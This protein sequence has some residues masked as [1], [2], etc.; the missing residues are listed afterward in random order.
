[1]FYLGLIVST[2]YVPGF[3]GAL[4]PT[5]WALLSIIL[6]FFLWRPVIPGPAFWLGASSFL[7]AIASVTWAP[8]ILSAAFGLWHFL[9]WALAFRL[10]ATNLDLPALFRGLAIGLTINSGVAVLQAFDLNPVQSQP[11]IAPAGLLFN[12]T[13]LGAA[14]ALTIVALL[15]L[16]QFRYLLGPLIGLALTESRGAWLILF[17]GLASRMLPRTVL[18][19]ALVPLAYFITLYPANSDAVRLYIWAHA[20]AHLSA[21]GNGIG[22]FDSYYYV[23]H[24]LLFRDPR[25]IHP[26]FVHNDYLQLWFELGI[27]AIP[28]YAILAIALGQTKFPLRATLLSAAISGLFYF[29]LW[30]PLIAFILCVLT[31][32]AVANWHYVRRSIVSWR[33]HDVP[34]ADSPR[35]IPNPSR[36]QNLPA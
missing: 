19:L 6:P 21:W 10:G 13:I 32:R 9:V 15:E 3:T 30:C 22:S 17:V 24:D 36:S 7:W 23:I 11:G 5:Q 20:L 14:C 18:A 28:L 26:E 35:P 34:W 33:S 2:C 1:M 27:G 8:S 31:G 4:L 29:P 12:P 25:L 16:R